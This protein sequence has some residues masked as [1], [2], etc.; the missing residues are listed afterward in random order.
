MPGQAVGIPPS[1]LTP[2][3]AGSLLV[4]LTCA[5]QLIRSLHIMSFF[6]GGDILH[7]FW[8]VEEKSMSHFAITTDER[9]ALDYFNTQH[10]HLSDEQFVIPLSK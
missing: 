6:S 1:H 7:Q 10:S 8:E 4:T 9:L 5:L 2:I 3:L